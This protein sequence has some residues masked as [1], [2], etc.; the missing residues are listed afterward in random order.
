MHIQHFIGHPSNGMHQKRPKGNVRHKMAIH[1]VD[2]N[3]LGTGLIYYAFSLDQ[4]A[5]YGPGVASRDVGSEL[6]WYADWKVTRRLTLSAVA[7]F[8][9][10]G[11]AVQQASGRTR[12][13]AY[14]MCYVGW[15]F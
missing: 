3:D 13:L 4:P 12:N 14:G 8:A 15:S 5:S 7:A 9:D 2:M 10:P 6:D 11:S 1:H